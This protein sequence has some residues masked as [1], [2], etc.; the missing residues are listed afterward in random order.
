MLKRAL[1][2][3]HTIQNRIR[4]SILQAFPLVAGEVSGKKSILHGFTKD[5]LAE[6]F[7][8]DE[9]LVE[10]IRSKPPET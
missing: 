10:D 1:C 7:N 9:G 5:V 8:V 4:D 2:L 3:N 6:A